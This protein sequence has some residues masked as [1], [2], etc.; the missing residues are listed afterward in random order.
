MNEK[1]QQLID[2][3]NSLRVIA[4]SGSRERNDLSDLVEQ[5]T[6]TELR[7]VYQALDLRGRQTFVWIVCTVCSYDAAH[8]ICWKTV[9][10][11]AYMDELALHQAEIDKM[12]SDLNAA[13]EKLRQAERRLCK[14]RASIL[15]QF[16]RLRCE[17]NRWRTTAWDR[18]QQALEL[19]R[20]IEEI[21]ERLDATQQRVT[22][23]EIFK[24]IALEGKPAVTP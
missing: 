1:Q 4:A 23:L 7:E 15:A 16:R 6:Y 5:R 17:R 14:R 13:Q 18:A 10:W 3:C 11:Q 2:T 21:E 24:C 8:Q 12:W 20:Q 9:G 22:D 19:N